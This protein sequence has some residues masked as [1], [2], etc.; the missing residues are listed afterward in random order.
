MKLFHNPH[1]MC[2][3]TKWNFANKIVIAK[4]SILQGQS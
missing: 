3:L 2:D 1:K 4:T